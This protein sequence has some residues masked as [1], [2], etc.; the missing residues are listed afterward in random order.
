M[1]TFERTGTQ[2]RKRPKNARFFKFLYCF[3]R[4]IFFALL[5]LFDRFTKRQQVNDR[6]RLKTCFFPFT[7]SDDHRSVIYFSSNKIERNVA[8]QIFRFNFFPHIN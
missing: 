6:K 1:T 8:Y 5:L 7:F 3:K 4:G 2:K